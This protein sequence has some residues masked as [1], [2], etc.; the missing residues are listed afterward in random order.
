VLQIYC[1]TQPND[2][3]SGETALDK[4]H[5]LAVEFRIDHSANHVALA[6][7]QMKQALLVFA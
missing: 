1:R 5:D 6:R 7:P 3:E 4:A 2:A